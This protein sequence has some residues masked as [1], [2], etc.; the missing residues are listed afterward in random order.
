MNNDDTGGRAGRAMTAL[1]L[2]IQVTAGVLP[3]HP[4]PSYSRA[5]NMSTDEWEEAQEANLTGERLAELNGQ[6]AG[7]A[8]LLQLQPDRVNWVR[9]EWVWL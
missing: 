6:A 8:L 2:T 1:K 5:Y 7:Y 9:T 4:D 3:G